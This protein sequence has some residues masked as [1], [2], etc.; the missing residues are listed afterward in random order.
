LVATNFHQLRD[1]APPIPLLPATQDRQA[2]RGPFQPLLESRW[3]KSWW[4]G[5]KAGRQHPL[6]GIVSS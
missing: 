4:W 3:Q 5:G 1:S 6:E 2:E